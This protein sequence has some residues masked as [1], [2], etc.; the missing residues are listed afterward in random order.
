MYAEATFQFRH[1]LSNSYHQVYLTIAKTSCWSRAFITFGSP[2][3]MKI[4]IIWP[5]WSGKTQL[6][7]LLHRT[8]QI[9]LFHTDHIVYKQNLLQKHPNN[10]KLGSCKL[11][12]IQK[13][14]N[15]RMNN[16]L[17]Y[18][19]TKHC[20]CRSHHLLWPKTIC[21]AISYCRKILP[22]TTKL[23]THQWSHTTTQIC[24]RLSSDSAR[25]HANSSG[26]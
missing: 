25:S 18:T 13:R 7:L 20:P 23:M 8:M 21:I 17:T 4:R 5:S 1:I 19:T 6:G 9:P 15:H 22:L 11:F 14:S 2:L 10:I 16:D 3:L 12:W 24:M 26:L